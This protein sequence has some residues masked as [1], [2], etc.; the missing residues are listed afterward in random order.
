MEITRSEPA[1][2]LQLVQISFSQRRSATVYF[3][4]L[5]SL[6]SGLHLI[7]VHL[8]GSAYLLLD[9]LRIDLIC[10]SSECAFTASEPAARSI[11]TTQTKGQSESNGDSSHHGPKQ[12]IDEIRRD[13]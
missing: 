2:V 5:T 1:I 10:G 7:F 13:L 3:P 11:L 4:M 8:C 12:L 6:T 9:L